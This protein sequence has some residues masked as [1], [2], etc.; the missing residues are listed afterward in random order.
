MEFQTFAHL[1]VGGVAAKATKFQSRDSPG[2]AEFLFQPTWQQLT[3]HQG[4][5]LKF[6]KT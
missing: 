5:P 1:T 3:F 6:V 4:W 2:L